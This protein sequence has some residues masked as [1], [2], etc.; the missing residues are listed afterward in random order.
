MNKLVLKVCAS[1]DG[2]GHFHITDLGDRE[3]VIKD[4]KNLSDGDVW[5]NEAESSFDIA[6]IEDE[7]EAIKL[8]EFEWEKFVRLFEQR[9]QMEIQELKIN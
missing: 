9:G 5:A 1:V 8:G 6:S 4:L 2:D 7:S 3:Q